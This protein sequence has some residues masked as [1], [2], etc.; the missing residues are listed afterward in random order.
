MCF[1]SYLL[2][3]ELRL[4]PNIGESVLQARGLVLSKIFASGESDIFVEV[5]AKIK[6]DVDT[7][8]F[9]RFGL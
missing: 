3:A 8:D 4:E 7:S 1:L 6:N 2:I 9:T 5:A